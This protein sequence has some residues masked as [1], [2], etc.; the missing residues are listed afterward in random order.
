[1][2]VPGGAYQA[3]LKDWLGLLVWAAGFNP[4]GQP[5][6][7]R[8]RF[9]SEASLHLSELERQKIATYP[10]KSAISIIS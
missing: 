4:V 1:M 7:V 3:F 6:M 10:D 5:C 2:L 9:D 8:P